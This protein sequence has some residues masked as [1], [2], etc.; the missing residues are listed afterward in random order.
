MSMMKPKVP[1]PPAAAP[2]APKLEAPKRELGDE[3]SREDLRKKKGR[4][5]LRIDPQSGGVNSKGGN[6]INVPMK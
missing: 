6:G 3:V 4:N 5:S 1:P 2:S